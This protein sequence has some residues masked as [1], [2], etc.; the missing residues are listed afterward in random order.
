MKRR[1]VEGPQNCTTSFMD[2]LVIM[3]FRLPV[4]ASGTVCRPTSPQLQRCLFFETASK[5][6][7][8]P[9]H[10]AAYTGFE[11]QKGSLSG[12]LCWCI[13]ASVVLHPVTWRQISSASLT[14]TLVGDCAL[15]VRQHLSVHVLC[16]LPSATVPSRQL[17]HLFGTVCQSQFGY[18]HHCQFFV[19]D[20]RPS[21]FSRSY[22][23]SD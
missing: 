20:G 16:V 3:Y 15:R 2:N 9:D 13:A 19:V 5:L 8:F 4:A 22:S 17:L 18:R 11:S 10:F 23:C 14:L 21:F 7:F 6:I 1:G 12:W